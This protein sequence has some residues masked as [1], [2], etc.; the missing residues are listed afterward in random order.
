MSHP[1]E[2]YQAA[3][4]IRRMVEA[5]CER[6]TALQIGGTRRGAPADN[7]HSIECLKQDNA[8]LTIALEALE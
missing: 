5:N 3:E 1:N 7:R 2:R 4:H 6:I 8:A